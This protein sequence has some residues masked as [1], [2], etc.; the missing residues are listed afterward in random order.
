MGH[1]DQVKCAPQGLLRSHSFTSARTLLS[2]VAGSVNNLKRSTSLRPSVN[3]V[4]RRKTK[5]SSKD[6]PHSRCLC[7]NK[8]A[9]NNFFWSSKSRYR[10]ILNSFLDASFVEYY[11][12][13]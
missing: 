10:N 2:R 6:F 4:M 7:G 8:D 3:P 9:T 1:L 11:L 13:K 5:V 12:P